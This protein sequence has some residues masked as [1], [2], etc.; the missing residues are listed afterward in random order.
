VESKA[1]LRNLKT[2]PRKARLVADVVR[3][4]NVNEALNLLKLGIKKDVAEDI[5]KLISSAVAN[6]SNNNDA[7]VEVDSLRVSEI[8]VDEGPMMK[9]F[10]PRAKGSASPVLKRMCHISVTLSN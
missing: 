5:A 9:R 8:K 4:R 10:R 7:N 2:T 3:G 1:I 6:L